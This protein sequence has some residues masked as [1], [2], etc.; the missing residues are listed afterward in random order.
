MIKSIDLAKI[1]KESVLAR[2]RQEEI[3]QHY[4][5]VPIDLHFSFCSPLRQ[6]NEPTCSMGYFGGKLL[7]RD[8][9]EAKAL[10]CFDYVMRKYHESYGQALDRIVLDFD[11]LN[12]EPNNNIPE[13][14]T[15]TEYLN[16][17]KSV[18]KKVTVRV[19]AFTKTD[20]L[21]LK[22]FHITRRATDKFKCFSIQH[23]WLQGHP[24]YDYRDED[25]ALGYYL[26]EAGS[27]AQRWKVYFYMRSR[28]RFL[29][30]TNRINGW[31]QL[32]D[33]G[34]VVIL[35]KSMKD[36][37]VLDMFGIPAVAMQSETMM[38]YDR[39]IEEL[40][41]RFRRLY[42]L[43]DFD[44]AGIKGAMKI[45]RAYDIEPLFLTNGKFGSIDFKTK[46]I[47]DFVKRFG[48]HNTQTLLE[49]ASDKLS[50]DLN[51]SYQS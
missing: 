6:D 45:R 10:D 1:S 29:S 35:T 32:P 36:V 8:W 25:P 38:P 30:N 11:L 46:D 50:L 49:Y 40:R 51:L 43:Y 41:R 24:H 26:G 27:N 48:V 19:Q 5:E 3:F 20:I 12:V 37:M 15:S 7:F 23:I 4:L 42:T 17:G 44:Y 13:I 47:S 39:I 18:K 16:R 33:N 22:S 9:S 34:E 31:V 2:I 21:Y 28:G 14:F